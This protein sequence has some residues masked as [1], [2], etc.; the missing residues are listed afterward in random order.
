M[1]LLTIDGVAVADPKQFTVE[2]NN[3]HTEDSGRTQTGK[4]DITIVAV[5]RKLICVWSALTWKEAS[6]LL[7]AIEG[8]TYFKV[9]YPDPK[10]GKYTT[11]EFYVG[12]RS[13]PSVFMVDGKETWQGI[14]FNFIER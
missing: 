9:T 5:K 1:A 8:K 14:A 12:D 13:A 3:I 2:G 4:A 11:K 7:S 6:K 10:A